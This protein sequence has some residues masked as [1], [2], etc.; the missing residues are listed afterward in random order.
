MSTL[1]PLLRTHWRECLARA[2]PATCQLCGARADAS[3]AYVL[4]AR[5]VASLPPPAAQACAR[6]AI[7]LPATGQTLCGTCAKSP[8]A[9]DASAAVFAYAFPV[10]RLIHLFKYQAQMG[11]ATFFAQHAAHTLPRPQADAL[12]PMPLHPARQAARGFNQ[13]LELARALSRLWR[14]PLLADAVMRTQAGPPQVSLPLR[15]RRRNLR[16]AFAARRR[17][18]GLRLL[19]IDDVMT[20]GASLHALAAECK[21]HGAAQVRCL[22]LAR[23]ASHRLD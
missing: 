20:T 7:A 6:C 14:I 12:V 9:F 18:D 10:D 19:A 15:Q 1:I 22:V 23:T 11:L 2:L 17:L 13:S 4:C 5:C 8:P 21:R 3:A 16:R